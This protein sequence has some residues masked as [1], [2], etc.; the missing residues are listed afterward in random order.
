MHPVNLYEK[1][2]LNI[3]VDFEKANDIPQCPFRSIY[4]NQKQVNNTN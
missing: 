2:L 4:L 1:Y 3:H